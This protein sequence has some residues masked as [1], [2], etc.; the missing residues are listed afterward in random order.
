MKYLKEKE[1]IYTVKCL[2]HFVQAA[3]G[4]EIE[5][6]TL[7]EKIKHIIPEGT[8]TGYSI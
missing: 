8:Q 3:L 1:M 2:Y 4:G 6:P 7:E 5:I